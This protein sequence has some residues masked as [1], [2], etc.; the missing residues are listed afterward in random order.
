M[1]ATVTIEEANG[2]SD[3]SPATHT[4]VDGQNLGNGVD[5]DVRFASMDAC[6]KLSGLAVVFLHNITNRNGI[7]K[8]VHFRG[9]KASNEEFFQAEAPQTK[10]ICNPEYKDLL[11]IAD[12][13]TSAD[14]RRRQGHKYY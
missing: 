12:C 13:K 4:R 9:N 10:D 3:T 14:K 5:V 6:N 8:M 7:R 2:G 11:G 1:V